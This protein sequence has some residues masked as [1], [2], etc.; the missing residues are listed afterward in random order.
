MDWLPMH[1]GH[2]LM[3]HLPLVALPLAVLLDALN[4]RRSERPWRQVATVLW[5]LGLTGAAAA[6]TTGLVAYNRVEHSE[7]GHGVMTLHRNV[8]LGA[9]VLFL[10]S[11]VAR[12]R[13]PRSGPAVLVGALGVAAIVG[14]GYLGGEAVFRHA[15]GLPTAVLEQVMMER[16]GHVHGDEP[17]ESPARPAVDSGSPKAA[18]DSAV[19][20]RHDHPDTVP[21]SH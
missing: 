5:A 10:L 16:G 4:L 11:G 1:S 7:L 15:I 3:V 18:A 8:A 12:W 6:V 20:H 17:D 21:H 19:P 14:A 2:P 9:V 13:R